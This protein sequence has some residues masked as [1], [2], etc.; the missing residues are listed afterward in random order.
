M[1][2]SGYIKYEHDLDPTASTGQRHTMQEKYLTQ[3][4]HLSP[5]HSDMEA[6]KTPGNI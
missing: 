4:L 3:D 2:H 6:P 5:E 1:E